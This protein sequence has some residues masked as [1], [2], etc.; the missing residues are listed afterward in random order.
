MTT[1]ITG[2]VGLY[3]AINL[4]RHTINKKLITSA[5]HQIATSE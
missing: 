4:H 2:M 1:D 5:R 3:L